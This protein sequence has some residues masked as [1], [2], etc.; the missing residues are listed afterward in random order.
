MCVVM[1][2]SHSL[3]CSCVDILQGGK[4]TATVDGKLVVSGVSVAVTSG[5]VGFGTSGYFAAEFDAFVI[6]SGMLLHF[7]FVFGHYKSIY[8][9]KQLKST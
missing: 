7:N 8:C 6:H 5:Y 2:T 4:V 9:F 1:Y 3:L